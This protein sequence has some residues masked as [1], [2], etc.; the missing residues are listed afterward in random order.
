M[1]DEKEV[2]YL[3]Y[4]YENVYYALGPAVDDVYEV[5]KEEYQKQGGVL[6]QGYSDE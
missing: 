5:I 6:P 1:I 3:R 2:E 4:F